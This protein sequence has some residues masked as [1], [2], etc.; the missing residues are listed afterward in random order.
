MG[1]EK[2]AIAA[3]EW[4]MQISRTIMT[5]ARYAAL[6]ALAGCATGLTT[7]GPL[8]DAAENLD[9]NAQAMALHAGAESPGFGADAKELA[10]RTYDFR[11]LSD[12]GAGNSDVRQAFDRVSSSYAK[13]SDDVAHI[14]TQQAEGDLQPLADAYRNAQ[15]QMGISDR[16]A[17]AETPPVSQ[18]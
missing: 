4:S 17:S 11:V 14:G 1:L 6:L 12:R 3:P 2:C 7:S 16:S 9:R 5:T 8:P 13:V 10:Q 18:Q 15:M